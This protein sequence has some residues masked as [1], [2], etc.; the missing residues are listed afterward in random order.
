MF[1]IAELTLAEQ[2]K[3]TERR[4]EERKRLFNITDEDA[5]NMMAVKGHIEIHLDEL[6]ETFYRQQLEFSEIQLVIGDADTLSRLKNS[7]R[8]YILE[9]FS[10]TYDAIYINSRLRVGK[11]HKRI[12]V[13]PS[14]Y[15]AA[16]NRLMILL[17]EMLESHCKAGNCSRF[18]VEARKVSLSRLLMFDVHLVFETYTGAL[19]A[20]VEMA[21]QELERYAQD[22][23]ATVA[24][25]TQELKDLS[26][27][28]GLTG[29]LNQRAF[30][31]HLRTDLANA[32]RRDEPLT[33]VYFDLNGFKKLND[34]HGHRTGDQVLAHVG[35]VLLATIREIDS[36]CRY[37]GDEFCMILPGSQIIQANDVCKRVVQRFEAKAGQHGV[38]F[39][40]GISQAGPKTF[41]TVDELVNPFLTH[42]Q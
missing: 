6:V 27:Q 18:E 15:M 22:L 16:V 12:G 36:A 28:D 2:L 23:E 39:S 32:K 13:S 8:G 17:N 26:R 19:V 14:L 20:A 25:R 29:L 7:M 37:G 30:F 10:G 5:R 40:M 1:N 42:F 41:P 4:I 11:V 3:M 38:S 35:E 24:K 34:Q 9:L 33:L 21:Q 31:D